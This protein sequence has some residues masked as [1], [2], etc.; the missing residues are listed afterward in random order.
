MTIHESKC[1]ATIIFWDDASK[2]QVG[3]TQQGV[4]HLIE[5]DYAE[6]MRFWYGVID[7]SCEFDE[8]PSLIRVPDPLQLRM[9]LEFKDGR[10]GSGRMLTAKQHGYTHT[11]QFIGF[12]QLSSE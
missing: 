8:F 6:K 9:R 5:H 10:R 7:L 4:V 2:A 3:T 1:E 12:T 11:V